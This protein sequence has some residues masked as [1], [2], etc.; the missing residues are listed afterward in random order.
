MSSY[1]LSDFINIVHEE[2]ISPVFST[3]PI[4]SSKF[5]H[6]Y[7]YINQSLRG[8][9]HEVKMEIDKHVKPWD[10]YKKYTNNYE[11]INTSVCFKDKNI[12]V[13]TYTPISRS[14]YKMIEM[15]NHFNFSFPTNMRSFHLAEGPGGFIE[16]L[17]HKR[18]NKND[19]Y[20]GMT[21]M[22]DN[23][24]VPRWRKAK[25]FLNEHKNVKLIYG[26][27]NDGNLYMKHNL[28]FIQNTF[29]HSIDFITADGGFDYSSDFNAQEESSINL[30]VSEVIYAMILQKK[31]GSFILKVFDCFTN[32]MVDIIFVL[33]YLYDEVHFMKPFTS[34]T[35][36]SEKYIVCKN[37][38]MVANLDKIIAKFVKYFH[39]VEKYQLMNILAQ[40]CSDYFKI[41]LEEI[42]FIFGQQQVEN[43]SYTLNLISDSANDDK[44]D[45]IRLQ[46]ITKCIK[47]CKK[48]NMPIHNHVLA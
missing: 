47:W 29:A 46:N 25:A 24:D 37:F 18:Q 22:S 42:N 33:C 27:K 48:H 41:K 1:L 39:N 6:K 28:T 12:T 44:L 35:A 21:L 30:I 19:I 16:A 2:D 9:L 14:F 23:D 32:V 11:F 38:R 26:P 13:C 5:Q 36:N 17:S 7:I 20:Y 40:P 34:R 10:K 45:K 43:I 3:Q 15:L 31:G 4:T 8:Y